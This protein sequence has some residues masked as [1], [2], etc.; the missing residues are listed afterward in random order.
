MEYYA[1]LNPPFQTYFSADSQQAAL[2]YSKVTGMNY[3]CH[4]PLVIY[5]FLYFVLNVE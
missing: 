2:T 4:F 1:G 5:L 3:L